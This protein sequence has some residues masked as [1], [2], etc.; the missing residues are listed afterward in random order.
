MK[1][2]VE[3]R[4]PE[5]NHCQPQVPPPPWSAPTKLEKMTGSRTINRLKFIM[6]RVLIAEIT[7]LIYFLQFCVERRIGAGSRVGWL[8]TR[9]GHA[10]G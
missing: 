5:I 3:W 6:T 8:G 2:T 7:R 10:L 1:R 4:G 9:H